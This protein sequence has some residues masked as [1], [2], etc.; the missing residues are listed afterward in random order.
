M[1]SKRNI[2]GAVVEEVKNQ[3]ELQQPWK[4]EDEMVT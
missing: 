2:Q 4:E 3:T 1:A